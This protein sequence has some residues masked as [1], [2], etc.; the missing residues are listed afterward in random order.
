MKRIVVIP[1]LL[2]LALLSCGCSFPWGNPPALPDNSSVSYGTTSIAIAVRADEINTTS[3]EAKE[4]L[5][6]G[7]TYNAQN[8]QFSKALDCFDAALVLDPD[9]VDAYYAKGVA[10][11]NLH[12][13]E[14]A[15]F[16]YDQAL[17]R[18]PANPAVWILRGKALQGT[19]R[20]DE[21]EESFK[22]AAELDPTYTP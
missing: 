2:V 9:L 19:G 4:L 3:P 8:N 22:R 21:A 18:D 17:A 20:S 5:I 16:W 6:R 14:E 12:R 13:Y 15:L 1:I 10:L 7:L 11:H